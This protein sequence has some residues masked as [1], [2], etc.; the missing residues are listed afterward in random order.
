M[1]EKILDIHHPCSY[2]CANPSEKLGNKPPRRKLRRIKTC[3]FR[4]A[5]RVAKAIRVICEIC[6]LNRTII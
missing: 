4:T 2:T 6:G 3:R 1:A 5:L